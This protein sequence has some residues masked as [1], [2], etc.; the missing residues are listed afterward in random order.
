MELSDVESHL[1]H[2]L[3]EPRAA[4]AGEAASFDD[5][6]PFHIEIPSVEGPQALASVLEEAKQLGV[7]VHRVSQGSG[8]ALLRE[9]EVAEM[10]AIG[11]EHHVE[12]VLW[13]GLRASWE[14]SAMARSSSGASS[15]ATVRGEVGLR[16]ALEEAMRAAEAGIDGVLV[17]D[18]GVLR[19]LGRA[20]SAN[21]LPAS[22]VLKTSLALPCPNPETAR[23]YVAAGATTLNLPTDLPLE[24]IAAIRR[25]VDVPLDCYVEAPDDF[26]GTLRYHELPE[27]VHAA[28]PVHLKFGIRNAAGIYPSGGHLAPTV[29][30]MSKERVRRAAIALEALARAKLA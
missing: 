28:A 24:D 27:L 25:A 18:L 26:A 22:F 2:L 10:A 8:I 1:R 7:I 15:G 29:L 4:Q 16:A 30:A 19:L 14:V 21:V 13:A 5:G 11:A 3:G 23:A 20:K 9:A 12:V 17:S 6:A